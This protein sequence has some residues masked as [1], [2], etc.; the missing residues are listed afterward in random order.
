MVAFTTLD[1]IRQQI[2][3]D[4]HK[5]TPYRVGFYAGRRAVELA[6]PYTNPVS[7]DSFNQGVRLGQRHA[8]KKEST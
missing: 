4:G 7:T 6:C 5:V 2:R 1:E 3:A 8:T